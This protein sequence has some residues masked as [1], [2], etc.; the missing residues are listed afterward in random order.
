MS[1]RSSSVLVASVS[2]TASPVS[3][4]LSSTRAATFTASPI[5][6][7]SSRP[8]PPTEPTTT[9]PE[10]IPTPTSSSPWK[11]RPTA[12]TSSTPAAS[13]RSAWSEKR[14]GVP[15]TASRP[16]PRNLLAWPPCFRTTGTTTSNSSFSRATVSCALE[17][18]AKGVKSRMSTTITVASTSMPSSSAPSS[19]TR[20]ATSGST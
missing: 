8:P 14:S 12:S 17:R 6:A 15:N 19:I 18:S 3:L 16:S 13:A 9:G 10:L 2:S 5:T 7:N 11:C 4:V 1:E 20:S